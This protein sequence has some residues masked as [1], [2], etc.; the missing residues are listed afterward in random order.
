MEVFL[1]LPL[2]MVG[3]LFASP[4]HANPSW[5]IPNRLGVELALQTTGILP[6]HVSLVTG[7][8]TWRSDTE[9]N[10]H[11]HGTIEW[12]K[13]DGSDVLKPTTAQRPSD[14]HYC[15]RMPGNETV[16]GG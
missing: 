13:L 11:K 9:G 2:A 7:R 16:P 6:Q 5:D 3:M 15:M 4:V 1:K 10:T 8:T 12:K 14:N